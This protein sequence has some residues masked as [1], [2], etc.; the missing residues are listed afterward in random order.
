MTGHS[1]WEQGLPGDTGPA[2]DRSE[3]DTLAEDDENAPAWPPPPPPGWYGGPWYGGPGE[4]PRRN[5]YRGLIMAAVAVTAAAIGAM[6]ALGVMRWPASS[7]AAD[8]APTPGASSAAPT[9]G[10]GTGYPLPSAGPGG[11]SG[12]SGVHE[13]LM[14]AGKVAAVSAASITITAQGTFTAAITSATQF[15]GTVHSA[16]GIKVGD[17]VMIDVSVSANNSVATAIQDPFAGGSSLP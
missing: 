11:V 12:G 14:L 2:D 10:T 17:E 15:T 13:E 8:A 3:D 9:P 4:P 6:V 7:P 5:A 1:A 16:S